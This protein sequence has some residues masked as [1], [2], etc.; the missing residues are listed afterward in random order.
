MWICPYANGHLQATGRDAR[1][2]KQSRYHAHWREVRDENKYERMMAFAKALP[3][4]RERVEHDLKMQGLARQKVL[5]TVVRLLEVTFIRVGNEE[6]AKE[7]KSYGLTTMR[8]RHVQVKGSTVTFDFKG[9]SGVHHTINLNDRRMANIIKR[10]QDLPGYELF[11][12]VDNDG[13]HHAIDSSDVNQYLQEI[14]NQPFTAKDFRTWAGTVLACM[15]LR[16][17]DA[18]ES[19]TQ[20]KK[21]VRTAIVQ[22]ASRLGNTPTVCRKCYVH[23]AV[24]DCYLSGSMIETVEQR[25]KEEVSDTAES[26]RQDELAVLRLL[27][28]R[29]AQAA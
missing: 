24:L 3:A 10:C 13:S 23:P 11:Q 28:Q 9:K 27:E 20:A 18:F 16:E 29:L 4:I 12:Y 15:M 17:F 26:L 8:G 1:G 6:Y 22:V 21:N 2:R 5:A 14:S 25:V 7:N 19:D